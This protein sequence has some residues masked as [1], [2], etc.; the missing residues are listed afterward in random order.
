MALRDIILL[1]RYD[2]RNDETDVDASARQP[3]YITS[4]RAQEQ[5]DV[6][7]ITDVS[8]PDRVTIFSII[9]VAPVR[10]R[11]WS[12]RPIPENF[13]SGPDRLLLIHD[14]VNVTT[15]TVDDISPS[16]RKRW[17]VSCTEIADSAG[18]AFPFPD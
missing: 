6:L 7:G 12:M 15:Y 11:T 10:T 14:P 5:Y 17:R 13:F 1:L 16:S 4:V 9:G 3:D 8:D 2:I 18:I